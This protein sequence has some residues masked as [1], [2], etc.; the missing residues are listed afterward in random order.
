MGNK[1]NAVI[2]IATSYRHSAQNIA[3]HE[4]LE[5]NN[6]GDPEWKKGNYYAGKLFQKEACCC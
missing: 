6:Y 3:F 2:P 5:D 4:K 1:I